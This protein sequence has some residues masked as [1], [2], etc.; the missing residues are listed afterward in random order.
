MTIIIS[1]QLILRWSGLPLDWTEEV[2]RYC[3]VWLVY[4]ACSYGVKKRAHIK[5]DAVM[6]LFKGKAKGVLKI[7]SNVLF[8][9]FAAVVSYQGI[10]LLQKINATHQVSPAVQIPMVVPYASYTVGFILVMI[11]LIQDT[12]LLYIENFKSENS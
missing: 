2:A 10:L 7:I 9:V 12:I 5:V 8:F 1:L 4:I 6:L 11:R 3:F